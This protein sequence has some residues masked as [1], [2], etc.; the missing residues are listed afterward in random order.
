MLYN[1]KEAKLVLDGMAFDYITFGTGTKPLIMIQGLNTGGIRG[2]RLD[3][4]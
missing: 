1:A 2:D 3:G 4:G